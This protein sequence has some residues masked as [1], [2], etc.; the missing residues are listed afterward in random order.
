M[1]ICRNCSAPYRSG[2]C[3]QCG[4]PA[5]EEAREPVP[6]T[7]EPRDPAPPVDKP[8]EPTPPAGKP[9]EPVPPSGST[10]TPAPPSEEPLDHDKAVEYVARRLGDAAYDFVK[11]LLTRK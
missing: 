8:P 3:P 6:P 2:R 4:A 9:P 5:P 11:T 1:L 7:E 10:S